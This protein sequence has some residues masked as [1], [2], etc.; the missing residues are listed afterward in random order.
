MMKKYWK[1]I[2]IALVSVLAI[3]MFYINS[4]IAASPYPEFVI[5]TIQGNENEINNIVLNGTYY[6]RSINE[7]I[8]ITK[9]GSHYASERSFFDRLKGNPGKQMKQYQ[10]EYRNFMRGK[11]PDPASFVENKDYLVYGAI[12]YKPITMNPGGFEFTV[13][14]LN[15]KNDKTTD[16]DMDAPNGKYLGYIDVIDVQIVGD[17]LQL[18]TQSY[19]ENKMEI[20][21]YSFNMK[22]NS[23]IGESPIMSAAQ[24]QKENR[25]ADISM[26]NGTASNEVSKY[27]FLN[28]VIRE[29][30]QLNDGSSNSKEIDNELYVYNLETREKEAVKLPKELQVQ[31]KIF[32]GSTIYSMKTDEN[33][34]VV[35]PYNI[36]DKAV[37]AKF[38]IKQP[39]IDK[40][41][42]SFKAIKG[43]K[44]YV[45]VHGTDENKTATLTIVSLETGKS[46]YQGEI[47]KAKPAAEFD[48]CSLYLGDMEIE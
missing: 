1:L 2:A 48:N 10:T 14:I 3:G 31:E 46:L 25:Y 45:L 28:K 37:Q 43:G 12:E 40:D 36:E 30:V 21:L 27:I 11:Y 20:K 29:E 41:A 26:L 6:N 7:P 38:T 13:S 34:I 16:F 9:D 23:F 44:L 17:E 32:D 15:K 18:I 24:E 19:G 33:G 42:E 4:V 8:E 39:Q 5:K 35:T 22:T 47:V